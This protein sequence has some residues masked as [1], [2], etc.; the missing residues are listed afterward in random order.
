[1]LFLR[2]LSPFY[3]VVSLKLVTD[4]I[5]RGCGMMVRFMIATFSDLILRV[6][7]AIVLSSTALG[8]T[9]IWMAWPVGWCIGTGLS[10][11]FYFTAIRKVLAESLAKAEAEGK[12]AEHVQ[13]PS[14]PQML[15][16]RPCNPF[17]T[18]ELCSPDTQTK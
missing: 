11:V 6:G 3:F 9:G 17:A 8:S 15:K 10:L 5:L 16:W 7:I 1:M 2:I 12:A 13:R 18:C 4:G 14:S